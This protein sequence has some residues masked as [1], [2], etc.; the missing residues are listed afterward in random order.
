MI[1]V[2]G[3]TVPTKYVTIKFEKLNS[4]LNAIFR[5]FDDAAAAASLAAARL[6]YRIPIT[7]A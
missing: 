1:K 2:T 4:T 6:V 3:V 5:T 7:P